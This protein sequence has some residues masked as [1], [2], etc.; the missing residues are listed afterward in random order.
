MRKMV[1]KVKIKAVF[2]SAL[3]GNYQVKFSKQSI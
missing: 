3:V 1:P 2:V